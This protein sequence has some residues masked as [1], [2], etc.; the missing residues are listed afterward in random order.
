[1]WGIINIHSVTGVGHKEKKGKQYAFLFNYLMAS[2]D[3]VILCGDMNEPK[4]DSLNY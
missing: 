4:N 2:G 1:L 3:N